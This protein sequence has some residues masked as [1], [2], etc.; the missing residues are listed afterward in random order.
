MSEVLIRVHESYRWVVAVC[1]ADVFGMKLLDGK[2]V[3]DLSGKFFDGKSFSL[4]DAGA[5][6]ERCAAEDATFNFVGRKSVDLA[7][8]LGLVKDEGVIGIEGVP[9]ALVLL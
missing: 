6:L 9:V 4:S 3:L 2:R 8:G 1:D 7:K 5:E